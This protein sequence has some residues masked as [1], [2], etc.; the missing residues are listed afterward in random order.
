MPETKR[1]QVRELYACSQIEI[2][3]SFQLQ[4]PVLESCKAEAMLSL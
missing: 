3:Q 4:R 1:T 2:T